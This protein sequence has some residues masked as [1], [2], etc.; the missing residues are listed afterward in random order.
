MSITSTNRSNFIVGEQALSGPY[1]G[2]TLSDALAQTRRLTH[3]EIEGAVADK[4]YRGHGEE[5]TSVYLS[6]QKRGIKTRSLRK[7]LKRRQA[8]EP[9]IGHLK[10]HGRLGRNYLQGTAIVDV[11]LQY[12]LAPNKEK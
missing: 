12:T 3:T 11:N 4:G 2:H 7:R 10:S 5:A 6:G 1:D 8:I 9:I